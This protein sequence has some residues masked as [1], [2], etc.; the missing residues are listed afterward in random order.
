MVEQ[1]KDRPPP[2]PPNPI[3]EHT[4]PCR[5]STTG[6]EATRDNLVSHRVRLNQ[7]NR[8]HSYG[9]SQKSGR[10]KVNPASADQNSALRERKSAQSVSIPQPESRW[11]LQRERGPH[12]KNVPW[13]TNPQSSG[14]TMCAMQCPTPEWRTV[15]NGP[16]FWGN[17]RGTGRHKS[18]VPVFLGRRRPGQSGNRHGVKTKFG[19]SH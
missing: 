18:G 17:P 6:Q 1:S 7:A 19:K 11:P 5:V 14:G 16:R 3:R 2:P 10:R 9:M 8:L 13:K 15:Q 4:S 12:G